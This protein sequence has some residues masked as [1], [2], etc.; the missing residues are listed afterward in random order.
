MPKNELFSCLKDVRPAS[1]LSAAMIAAPLLLSP[2]G[3][4]AEWKPTRNV[5]VLVPAGVGGGNDRA[6]RM[7]H[8]ILKDHKLLPVSVSIVNKPGAGGAIAY[9]YLNQFKGNGHH[10]A[11][12]PTSLL[13]RAISGRSDITFRQLTPLG[14]LFNEY[15]VLM[16]RNDS[17]LKSGKHLIETLKKDI[18]STSFAIGTSRVNTNGIAIATVLNAVGMD[19][20]DLRVL[21]HKS[22]GKS[23]AAVLGGHVDVYGTSVGSAQKRLKKGKMRGLAISSPKQLGGDVADIPTWKEQGVDIE[24]FGLRGLIGP[25]GLSK[26]QIAY[27]DEIIGK[28]VETK[29]FKAYAKKS[30]AVINYN[31]AANTYAL[32]T[33]LEKEWSILMKKLGLVKKKKMK[34]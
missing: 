32:L 10:I 29:E 13:T 26:D 2:A 33:S 12:Y 31:N 15:S 28:V 27:W 20:R 34:K 18:H 5:E 24:F 23:Y 4:D 3:A 19:Y 30:G 9:A 14:H 17:P 7:V 22:G 16:V 21:T 1:V 25:G 8:K 6:A 11:L